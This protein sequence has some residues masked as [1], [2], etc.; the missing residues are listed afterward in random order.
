MKG[1]IHIT[2]ADQTRLLSIMDGMKA[3]DERLRRWLDL[4]EHELDRANVVE[5]HAIPRGT[6]TL[7]SRVRLLDLD[8]G[9]S[10]VYK[11]VTPSE[12]NSASG[13]LSILAPIGIALLG[14]GEGERFECETPGGTRR[15]FVESVLFQ[16]EADLFTRRTPVGSQDGAE[17]PAGDRAR[18][19][20]EAQPLLT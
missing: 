8:S 10:M 1:Q 5:S 4:L 18:K 2:K 7:H 20:G 6:V 15:F 17:K 12:V 3:A 19:E 11:L 9:E 16:P 13:N 14:Y